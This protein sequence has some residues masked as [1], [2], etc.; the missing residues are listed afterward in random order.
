[1]A[2]EIAE[3]A[4]VNEVSRFAVF[5]LTGSEVKVLNTN[6]LNEAGVTRVEIQATTKS[7][8]IKVRYVIGLDQWLNC[9]LDFHLSILSNGATA[10]KIQPSTLPF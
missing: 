7:V 2:E 8:G 6:F 10:M 1:M 9:L 3:V 4:S 5:D